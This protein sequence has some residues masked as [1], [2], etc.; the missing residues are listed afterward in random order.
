MFNRTFLF[1]LLQYR[2]KSVTRQ[3]SLPQVCTPCSLP[4]HRP[5]LF[6]CQGPPSLL[7]LLLPISYKS[8][9]NFL[10][11]LFF[12]LPPTNFLLPFPYQY[13]T[14][15]HLTISY[16]LPLSN[17]LHLSYPPPRILLL[18]SYSPHPH[19]QYEMEAGGAVCI[20]RNWGIYQPDN[21]SQ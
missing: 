15:F 8:T 16:Y 5:V 1:R 4:W 12:Y 10:V 9:N 18:P 20:C 11:Q 7:L 21:F 3:K 17:L 6:P 13:P 2:L 14:A 19:I